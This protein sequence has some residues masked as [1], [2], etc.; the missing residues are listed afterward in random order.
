MNWKPS[1]KLLA[2]ALI[3]LTAS[4]CS[5][6]RKAVQL[7]DV[8]SNTSEVSSDTLRYH[9]VVTILDTVKEVTTI[10]VRENEQGDTL[11][12]FTVTDRIRASTRDRYHDV[13]EKVLVRTDT[14]YVEKQSESASTVV[15]GS[16][17]EVLPDGAIRPRGVIL[18]WICF[19]LVAIIVLIIT[20]KI[21]IK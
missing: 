5:I 10:T 21:F 18:K 3:A 2:I 6:N 14:V 1:K 20:I 17:T 16:T 13:Q 11:R 19:I 8:R 15:T 7:S 9:V 4:A 12:M